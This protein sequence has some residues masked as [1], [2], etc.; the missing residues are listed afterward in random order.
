[1]LRISNKDGAPVACIPLYQ[2]LYKSHS[3]NSVLFHKATSE[4]MPLIRLGL[5]SFTV[6]DEERAQLVGAYEKSY[7]SLQLIEVVTEIQSKH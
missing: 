4:R 3:N 5:G 1:M 6:E 7:E 2:K